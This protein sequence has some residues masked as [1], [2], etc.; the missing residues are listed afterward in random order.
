VDPVP[1]KPKAGFGH[2]TAVAV[3]CDVLGLAAKVL[4][5]A[6]RERPADAV[7]RDVLRATPGL[8][9]ED[10]GEVSR[11]VF[12]HFRWLGW[13]DP[14]RPVRARL[15]HA[16]ELAAAF[17]ERP[18]TF[19][20]E[21]LLAR[22]VPPWF[23]ASAD[24]SPAWVRSLQ[25]EPRLWLRARKGQGKALAERLG[26]C[27]A[28]D[29]PALA[30]A[31][32]YRG[33]EDLFRTPEFHAGEFELQDINSQAV[34]LICD[35]RP[36]ATWWDVA[37]GEGGKTLHLSD[38]MANQGLIWA[39]DRA[40]WRLRQLKRR[41]GRA[42]CFNY[43]AVI[44]DGGP[45]LPTRT[46]FDGVLV[47]APCSG[48]GTW[49]RNPHAR[50]TTTP[51]DVQAL[52]GIQEQLLERVAPAVKPGGRLVYAVCTL[53]R[54]E[55]LDVTETFAAQCPDFVPLAVRSP[56]RPEEGHFPLWLLPQDT[57]GNGMF[58]AVWERRR[59]ES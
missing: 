33:A 57:G 50:W 16:E 8:R 25:T 51:E 45:K 40:G 26:G 36:G 29:V 18:G 32:E 28:S 24:V 20:D 5:A 23:R 31:V 1:T 22:A 55:T 10:R 21:K 42:R 56:F 3:S 9:N 38:L 27:R 4:A 34:S 15:Q 46:R 35:P 13:L 12:R 53:T 2:A 49:Q 48:T 41:A 58:V 7:L 11:A 59:L 43:R 17:E 39:S 52:A 6:G 47:D 54:A 14:H 44:W 37:A 19:S 30:D